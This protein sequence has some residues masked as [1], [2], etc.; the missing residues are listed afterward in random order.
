MTQTS[1]RWIRWVAEASAT[2]VPLPW[3][4]GKPPRGLGLRAARD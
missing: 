2:D 4:R 1:S 3:S